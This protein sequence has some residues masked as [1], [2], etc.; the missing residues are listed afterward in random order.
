MSCDPSFLQRPESVEALIAALPAQVPR[1][2]DANVYIQGTG[3]YSFEFTGVRNVD[4]LLLSGIG[5]SS[6]VSEV[7]QSVVDG[8]RVGGAVGGGGS[9]VIPIP[10]N[11][12]A[13]LMLNEGTRITMGQVWKYQDEALLG[14]IFVIV[15]VLL[16][17]ARLKV[18]PGILA[19]IFVP[20]LVLIVM[21]LLYIFGFQRRIPLDK[22]LVMNVK[23]TMAVRLACNDTSPS[24]PQLPPFSASESGLDLSDDFGISLRLHDD[25]SL[26]ALVS[27][28]NSMIRQSLARFGDSLVQ[29][30]L[31]PILNTTLVSHLAGEQ[32]SG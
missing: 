14:I 22:A 6:A 30:Q 5:G 17:A 23:G 15:V 2:I 7:L 16:V 32:G 19:M 11:E 18:R 25:V 26:D 20:L 24:T 10:I 13:D 28:I 31:V 12:R 21:L 4:K 1:S 9:L 29:T 8:I 3:G 27:L